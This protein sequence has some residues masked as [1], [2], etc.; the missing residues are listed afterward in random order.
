MIEIIK[1]VGEMQGKVEKLRTQGKKI[2]LVP[3]MGYLHEGHLSLIRLAREQCDLV[4]TSIFV[5]PTQFGPNEDFLQ[6][7]RDLDRDIRLAEQA[8]CDIIFY[9]SDTE[10][11]PP[12]YLT[13]LD[14]KKITQV[15]CGQS[16]P[17][18][19]Q[20]VTT[21]VCKLFNIVKPHIAVFGQ[22]DAQQ[23]TVIRQMVQDLNFDLEIIV[24]PT[25]RDADGLA[26][27]SRNAFLTSQER[28]DATVLY[29][30]L[31]HAGTLVNEG[32]TDADIVKNEMK[33]I[34]MSVETSTIDYIAV[35]NNSTLHD[36]KTIRGEVLI[37]LAVKIGSTRLIDNMILKTA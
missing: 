33:K 25:I 18:H 37:A 19:F 34:I 10:M 27:S 36:I 16:R 21:I 15:L 20:G 32:I 6:Y 30:A 11:Y 17:G 4:V 14:V 1:T 5:N 26:K 23:A 29:R 12:G 2:G 3:T 31:Q 13:Y 7:P 24:A 8:G 22:K 9:P 35:V 28:K